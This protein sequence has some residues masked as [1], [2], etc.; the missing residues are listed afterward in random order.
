MKNIIVLFPKNK[1]IG[2]DYIFD[3]FAFITPFDAI[4]NMS[5]NVSCLGLIDT[6]ILLC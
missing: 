5:T 1:T 2:V 4:L 6:M 3:H